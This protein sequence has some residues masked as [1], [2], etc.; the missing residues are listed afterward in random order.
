MINL[1]DNGT[2]DFAFLLEQMGKD[3]TINDNPVKA[4]I[5]NTNLEQNYD[6]RRITSLSPLS[7]GDIV[8]YNGKK[9]MVVSEVT[10]K[11][12]TKFKGIMRFLPHRIIVNSESRFYTL[13]CYI[14]TT[15]LGITSGKVLTLADGEIVVNCS[16]YS[17]DSGLKIGARFLLNGQAF[18]INGV[19]DFSKPGTVALTC[20]KDSILPTDDLINGIAGGLGISVNITNSNF[21]VTIGSTYQLTWTSTNNAPVRF[22]SSDESVAT[23]DANG[24][25][26]GLSVGTVTITAYHSQ[27]EQIKDTITLTVKDVPVAYTVEITSSSKPAEVTKGRTKTYEVIVKQGTDVVS[28]PVTW[29]IT[30]DSQT[31]TT[32]F[33]KITSQTGTSCVVSGDTLGYVQLK[34]TLVSDPSVF[35]W[36]RIQVKS[37]I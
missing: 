33:A 22:V 26:T 27:L 30:A 21:D 15:D 17:I 37:A 1:F 24:L 29:Q 11:R 25:V 14:N 20:V 16:N 12:Y 36:Q 32:T 35:A 31:G 13:D 18:K 9:F 23:V 5:T 28:E 7:R 3:I 34:A 10:E 4:V 6:D 8:F 2:D 19:D